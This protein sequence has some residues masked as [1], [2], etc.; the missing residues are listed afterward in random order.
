MTKAQMKE[1]ISECIQQKKIC[2]AYFR[3]D[4]FYWNLIPLTAN[5]KL[6]LSVK[7]DDFLING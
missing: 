1:L 7:E 4:P 5:D 2:N 3:Y 6:F